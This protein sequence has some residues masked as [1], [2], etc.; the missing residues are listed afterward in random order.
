MTKRN[1]YE[2]PPLVEAI[3]AIHL[4]TGETW[5]WTIPGLLYG[6][7]KEQF[8][9]KSQ[10]QSIQF[11]VAQ[12]AKNPRI[13]GVPVKMRFTKEDGSQLVQIAP[14]ML[15]YNTVE[16]GYPGWESF[17][18]SFSEIVGSYSQVYPEAKIN[19]LGLR[20]INDVHIPNDEQENINLD[21]WFKL[22]VQLPEMEQ[23]YSQEGLLMRTTMKFLQP[24][25]LMN[26]TFVRE[27]RVAK[28]KV[29]FRL[30]LDMFKL[31][32]SAICIADALPRLRE[33]LVDAHNIIEATF[34]NAFTDK[35]QYEIFGMSS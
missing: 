35:T 21:D 1:I 25:L 5:D 2:T 32:D 4:E 14:D 17:L 10:E 27:Q 22:G 8:P 28:D 31:F 16:E 9:K 15:T 30:D 24:E 26:L 29:L 6:K 3:I 19:R 33:W 18:I 12:N 7:L 34:S 20:Y 23:K 13:Q 11:E